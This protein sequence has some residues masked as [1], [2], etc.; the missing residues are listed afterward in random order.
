VTRYVAFDFHRRC[1][2]FHYENLSELLDAIGDDLDE[3]GFFLREGNAVG[4]RQTG[5]VRTNCIDSTDRTNVF[6]GYL[7]RHNFAVMLK[8]S[9]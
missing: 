1:A 7:G 5:V 4:R 2:G 6:Q 9:F 3:A 8:V